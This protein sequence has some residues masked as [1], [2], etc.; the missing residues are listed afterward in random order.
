MSDALVLRAS[1]KLEAGQI[2]IGVHLD[3]LHSNLVQLE[4][5]IQ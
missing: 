4:N 3:V 1:S 2:P 5:N